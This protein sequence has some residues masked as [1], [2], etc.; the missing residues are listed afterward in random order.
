MIEGRDP[1]DEYAEERR[2]WE[3]QD[4]VKGYDYLAEYILQ[5]SGLKTEIYTLRNEY[6]SW[7]TLYDD[8]LIANNAAKNV[9]PKEEGIGV[10]QYKQL[11]D[12]YKKMLKEANDELEHERGRLS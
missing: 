10:E 5:S 3:F 2:I 12:T 6:K 8:L 7:K 9:I 4:R 1:S 11:L